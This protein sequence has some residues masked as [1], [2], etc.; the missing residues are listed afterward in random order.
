[1]PD[2]IDSI[3]LRSEV[4][5]ELLTAV[6]VWMIRWG[7]TLIFFLI[8]GVL[9]ITFYVK[10]PD[11]ISAEAMITTE[12]PPYKEYA[13]TSG[14][15]DT[16]L[17]ADNQIVKAHM[18]L[19]IIEN[20]AN[21][22]DVF[23]LKSIIDTIIPYNNHLRFPSDQIPLLFLG[24]IAS[25]YALFENSYHQY[26]L[27]KKW[28]PFSNEALANHQTLSELNS[29]LEN[30]EVQQELNAAEM[31]VK[32]RGLE[33]S[34]LLFEQ[35]VIST[36]EYEN[37]QL[38]ILQANQNLKNR[39][40]VI[41]Q[42]KEAINNANLL[43]KNTSMNQSK[44]EQLLFRNV[45]QSFQ[46]LKKAIK[47]W[48]FKYVLKSNIDGQVSFLDYW[49][50]NQHINVGDLV[51][52]IIPQRNTD[53]LAKLKTPNLNSGKVKIGQTVNIRLRNYPEAE[54]GLLEGKVQKISQMTD[55]DGFYIVDVDLPDRLITS[56]KKEL[57][58]KQEMEGAAEIITEELRLIERFFYQFKGVFKG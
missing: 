28:Q 26:M 43:S 17:V 20:T 27:N 54:Y 49:S 42:T 55:K 33:R 46:Q 21:F 9:A 31:E 50:E 19:A 12:L 4:V 13:K 22:E 41:S 56:Y 38:E 2:N 44:E 18:P 52:T 6:P 29:R 10:Y 35:G 24:D 57:E 23:L 7:N 34:K 16:L 3:S 5:Q 37:K 40:L 45:I 1:M 15:L 30:L 51:M 53:Y 25:D 14:Q 11:I 8:L 47:E 36:E 58:F 32:K 48:E 39:K